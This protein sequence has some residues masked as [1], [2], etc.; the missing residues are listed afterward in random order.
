MYLF[1]PEKAQVFSKPDGPLRASM[2]VR[3]AAEQTDSPWVDATEAAETDELDSIYFS[4]DA[5]WSPYGHRW[6]ANLL[7]ERIVQLDY[8]DPLSNSSGAEQ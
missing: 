6:V 3:S 8:L 4:G 7:K 5:H 1:V 2:V